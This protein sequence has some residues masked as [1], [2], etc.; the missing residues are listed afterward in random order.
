MA[1]SESFRPSPSAGIIAAG[2]ITSVAATTVA[3]NRLET[4]GRKLNAV[5]R[6]DGARVL[7]AAEVADKLRATGAAL[8][9][10]HGVPLAH[11][12]LFYRAGDLSAGGSKIRADFR[13]DV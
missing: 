3:L 12:D 4:V 2:D 11:K 7:E 1:S 10:L 13:A 5:V 6:L 9:P 8:P